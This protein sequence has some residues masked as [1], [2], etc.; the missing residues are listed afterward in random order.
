ME[1][2]FALFLPRL[3]EI[4]SAKGN[5]NEYDLN[6]NILIIAVELPGSLWQ[7]S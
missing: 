6:L 2:Y 1:K 3:A 4:N 5:G 7:C